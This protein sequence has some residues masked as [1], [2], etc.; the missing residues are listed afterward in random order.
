LASDVRLRHSAGEGDWP[1]KADAETARS[2]AKVTTS[3]SAGRLRAFL[4]L[5]AVA[6]VGALAAG[7]G[8]SEDETSTAPAATK[9]AFVKQGNAVLCTKTKAVADAA[10]R[11][12][13]QSP[14][15]QELKNFV[16][17]GVLPAVQTAHDDLASLDRPAGDEEQITAILA[18]LQS[19]IDATQ[20]NPAQLVTGPDPFTK[21]D[22]LILEYGLQD[23]AA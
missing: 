6:V 18:E 7:C 2:G 8:A 11:L 13:P 14:S 1:S 5:I 20:A 12:D 16:L 17:K 10:A 4:S 15:R 21:A 23:C 9:A 19:T 3:S 22:K